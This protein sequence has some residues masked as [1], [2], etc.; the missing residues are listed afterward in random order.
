MNLQKDITVMKQSTTNV[1]KC[2]FFP[3][4]SIKYEIH[5]LITL[6]SKFLF[7]NL[8]TEMRTDK[9]CFR[10]FNKMNKVFDSVEWCNV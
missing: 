5:Y 6:I 7:F 8:L 9:L 2:C 3:V 10:G 4:S 1:G